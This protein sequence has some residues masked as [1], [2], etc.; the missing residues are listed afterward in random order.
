MTLAIDK[1]CNPKPVQ[2][3]VAQFES[4]HVGLF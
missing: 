3:L 1:R 2:T 4:P